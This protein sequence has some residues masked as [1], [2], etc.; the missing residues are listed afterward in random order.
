[1][2]LTFV[3]MLGEQLSIIGGHWMGYTVTAK[4]QVALLLH[5]SVALQVTLVVPCGNV[6][7]LGGVQTRVGGG[8]HPPLAV[9]V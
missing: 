8:P 3:V 5:A 2:Q 9:L 1:V 6:L 7:P 4:L